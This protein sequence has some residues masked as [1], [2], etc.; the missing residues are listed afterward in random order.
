MS[1]RSSN[2]HFNM[3]IM[4]SVNSTSWRYI[5]I[6]VYTSCLV[7]QLCPL[8][9]TSQTVVFQAPLSMGFSRQ[10]YWSGLPF[11][12]PGDLLNPGIKHGSPALQVNSLPSEPPGKALYVHIYT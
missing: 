4:L 10:E 2:T 3:C 8:F 6:Y 1:K 5:H 9:A 12:S 11:P 7:T